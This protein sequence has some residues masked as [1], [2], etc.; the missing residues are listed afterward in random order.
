MPPNPFAAPG[1]IT[2]RPPEGDRDGSFC[3]ENTHCGP[4]TRDFRLIDR[5][6]TIAKILSLAI[7]SI[8]CVSHESSSKR[9]RVNPLT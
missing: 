8:A 2:Q 5:K 1:A 3:P 7:F 6:K 4:K 9:F